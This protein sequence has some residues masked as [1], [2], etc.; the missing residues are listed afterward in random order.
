M[1]ILL[2][3]CMFM[4]TYIY[5]NTLCLFRKDRNVSTIQFVDDSMSS[6]VGDE[7]ADGEM[8][9]TTDKDND[10]AN[11]NCA[12]QGRGGWWYGKCTFSSLN[13]EYDN[14][15]KFKGINWQT[16]KGMSY[17]LKASKMK[18]RRP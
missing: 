3:S 6:I 9:S 10:P 18:L 8:F 12:A 17:S 2:C 4:H 7:K 1:Y 11:S 13:G 16:F 15:S 14:N 5:V